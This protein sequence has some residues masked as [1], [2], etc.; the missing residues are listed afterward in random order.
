M[1]QASSSIAPFSFSSCIGFIPVLLGLP[2]RMFLDFVTCSAH[3]MY[4]L[5]V[6]VVLLCCMLN[7]LHED[8]LCEKNNARLLMWCCEN[9]AIAEGCLLEVSWPFLAYEKHT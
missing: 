8:S 4:L 9:C 5:V 6:T 1:S 7:A 2:V 3:I